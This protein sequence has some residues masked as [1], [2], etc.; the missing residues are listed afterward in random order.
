M[1]LVSLEFPFFDKI[2]SMVLEFPIELTR[3]SYILNFSCIRIFI[4]MKKYLVIRT[5]RKIFDSENW[6]FRKITLFIDAGWK[7]RV[8]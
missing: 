1:S 7:M 3:F 2:I 6:K 4:W 5:Q 8:G